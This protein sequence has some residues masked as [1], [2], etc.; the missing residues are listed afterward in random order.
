MK[1]SGWV[2]VGLWESVHIVAGQAQARPFDRHAQAVT[3]DVV[4]VVAR[5]AAHLSVGQTNFPGQKRYVPERRA[6][7]IGS[8]PH[9]G[10]TDGMIPARIADVTAGRTQPLVARF[11]GAYAV[12]ASETVV[13][14]GIQHRTTACA[15][16]AF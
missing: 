1:Y 15:R 11:A 5:D 4:E 16:L 12:M 9:V 14:H 7:M 6:S 8:A 2:P 3:L 13:R 10:Y